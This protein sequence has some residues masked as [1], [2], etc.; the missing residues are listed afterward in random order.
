[1]K[2]KKFITNPYLLISVSA[3]LSAL[4]LTFSNLFFLSWISFI[5][6]FYVI[7][8]HSKDKLKHAFAQGFLFGFIYH[9]FIYYWFWWF[10][11][12]DFAGLGTLA[13]IGVVLLTSVGIS[14]AHGVLWCIP[15][16]I[17]FAL[18]KIT[19]N[20][21]FLSFAAIVST[22]AIP[23]VASLGELSFPWVR[24]SL[25][26]YKATALIQSASLFGIDGV[27]FIILTVNALLTVF[28]LTKS[29]K[30]IVAIA[31]AAVI[32]TTNLCFGVIRLN[33]TSSERELKIMT[34]QG[35]VPQNE[36]WASNGPAVCFD[37]YSTLT[38]ENFTEG[39]GLILWPESA[40]PKVYTSEKKLKQYK[41]LSKELDTPILAGILIENGKK[42]TN[43][44][45]LI[46]KDEVKANYAKRHLVPFGEFMPYEKALSKIF[47]FLTELNI[48]ED[49]YIS[50]SDSVIMQINGGK[51]GNIICFENIYPELCRQSTLDGAEVII[52]ASND[53][54]L[55]DSPAMTQ[56][57]AHAVFRSVEN[58]RYLVRSANSGISAVIDS[59]GNIKSQLD[60]DYEGT[61]TDTVCFEDH[62]T[63]Y[64]KVGNI[65]FPTLC[66]C[67]GIL[68]VIFLIKRIKNKKS[69]K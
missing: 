56:H 55:K 66:G 24:L 20:P 8:T 63:L 48:I 68:S 57:L 45:I 10:Y 13:S 51:L 54:W 9:L 69:A 40:V 17:C 42:N 67:L 65:L 23:K 50:G 12:L 26:Q 4:P 28:L 2:F 59:R 34:V 46:D 16:V 3:I 6:F 36:K 18:K 29:K 38:K 11:P 7:I 32:F 60:I 22:L 14:I 37:T 43:S 61:L 15:F 58:G 44:N 5:P 30:R 1:M 47:P 27:D 49:D 33:N 19:K 35:S 21:L 39:V 31:A 41:Q 52:E 62:L 53:S 25:G 64:T